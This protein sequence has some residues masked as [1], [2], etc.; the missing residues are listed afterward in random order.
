[1][2]SVRC[3]AVSPSS[4]ARFTSALWWTTNSSTKLTC[5]WADQNTGI[6]NSWGIGTKIPIQ[7]FR[8]N[9][10]NFLTLQDHK[11]NV[12]ASLEKPRKNIL[13]RNSRKKQKKISNYNI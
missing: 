12:L 7:H 4:S 11:Q 8:N 5:P 9:A 3:S 13:S 2:W 6:A 1:L 10:K